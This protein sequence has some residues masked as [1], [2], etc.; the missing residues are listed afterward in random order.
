MTIEILVGI[1]AAAAVVLALLL[2]VIVRKG[3]PFTSGDVFRASRWSKG[4]HLF[5]TQVAISRTS[6]IRYTPHWIGKVE[7]TIHVAHVASVRIDTK[8]VFSDVFIESSGGVDP[9][10]C[11]GHRKKDAVRIK[12]LIDRYQ[13]E[14]FRGPVSSVPAPA[15]PRPQ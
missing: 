7:E 4:N 14:Y 5:P 15:P 6:V 1:A 12:E 8:L 13:S 2:L 10:S 3:R 9:I 11:Y